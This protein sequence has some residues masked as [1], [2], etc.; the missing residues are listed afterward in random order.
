MNK[1]D[2]LVEVRLPLKE[3][4]ALREILEREQAYSLLINKLRSWWVFAVAG[5]AIT[6]M[7]FWDK[8]TGVLK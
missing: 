3:Y 7:S 5:G 6:L 1:N 4:K 8:F 2:E